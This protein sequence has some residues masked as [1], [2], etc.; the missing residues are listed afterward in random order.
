MI[1]VNLTS[2]RFQSHFPYLL[3]IGWSIKTLT[4]NGK[5]LDTLDP[6]QPIQL[7]FHKADTTIHL[8]IFYP[9]NNYYW[10]GGIPHH[11][12]PLLSTQAWYNATQFIHGKHDAIYD[13][14]ELFNSLINFP[15]DLVYFLMQFRSSKFIDCSDQQAKHF[16]TLNPV[17]KSQNEAQVQ[18][19]IR[20][21]KFLSKHLMVD[22][23]MISSSLLSL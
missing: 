14:F 3:S 11:L 23:W 5:Y 8:L 1:E 6:I 22:I 10:I 17:P 15:T 18:N 20:S 21:M 9:R 4:A 19:R 7:F 2:F 13:S 12:R 16:L